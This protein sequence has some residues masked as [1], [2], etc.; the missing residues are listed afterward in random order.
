MTLQK[1]AVTFSLQDWKE[2]INGR[3][4]VCEYGVIKSQ[5]TLVPPARDPQGTREAEMVGH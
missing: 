1:E 5:L 4:L 2:A 3:M